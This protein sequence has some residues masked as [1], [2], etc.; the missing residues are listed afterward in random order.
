MHVLRRSFETARS[1]RPN[2]PPH[3]PT[4]Q[5]RSGRDRISDNTLEDIKLLRH[6]HR[7]PV[8]ATASKL[9]MMSQGDHTHPCMHISILKV[10]FYRIYQNYWMAYSLINETKDPDDRGHKNPK[11]QKMSIFVKSTLVIAATVTLAYALGQYKSESIYT[12][13]QIDAPTEVVWAELTKTNEYENWN[14]LIKEFKGEI[15]VGNQLDVTIQPPDGSAIRFYPIVLEASDNEEL[16]WVGSLGF[17]GV[18]DGEHYF[19]LE[20]QADGTTLFRHGETFTGMLA[21]LFFVIFEEDTIKGFDTMNVALKQRA[22][23]NS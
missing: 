11:E 8:F 15:K 6:Q 10:S 18:L 22:E 1:P 21:D 16:R 2:G 9:R 4:Q 12:E 19:K 14:P 5:E 13:I 20:E 3:S 7:L 23:A 17:K